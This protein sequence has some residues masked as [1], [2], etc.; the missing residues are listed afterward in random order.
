MPIIPL[1]M[2]L[3]EQ[4]YFLITESLPNDMYL[5]PQENKQLKK[6]Y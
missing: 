4:Q 5:P 2:R 3:L 6:P 1:A